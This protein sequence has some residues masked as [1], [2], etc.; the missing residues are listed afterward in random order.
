[1]KYHVS[2]AL[3]AV[4]LLAAFHVSPTAQASPALARRLALRL[5]LPSVRVT[6]QPVPM[7]DNFWL[8]GIGR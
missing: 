4:A 1:M 7:P 8:A 3:L 6:P 5:R 2:F